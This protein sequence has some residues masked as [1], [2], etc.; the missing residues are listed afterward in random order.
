M[1]DQEFCVWLTGR[2]LQ[3]LSDVLWDLIDNEQQFQ[4]F[5]GLAQE[6]KTATAIV[7]ALTGGEGAAQ[8]QLHMGKSIER[9][10][11]M[12]DCHDR[13]HVVLK[14]NGLCGCKLVEAV[15]DVFVNMS[16]SS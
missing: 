12:V 3:Q 1:A 16:E 14:E 5:V 7:D 13:I 11:Q 2:Q 4:E 8:L 6:D 9:Q 10:R 15:E